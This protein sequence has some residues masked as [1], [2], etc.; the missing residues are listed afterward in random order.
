MKAPSTKVAWIALGSNIGDSVQLLTEAA[1]RLQELS[2]HPIVTSSLW[3]TTPVDCPPGSPLFINAVVGLVPRR[4]ET[5]DSL[6]A[7]LKELEAAFG[8]RAKVVLN[9]PRPL[10]LD[11]IAFGGE[12]RSTEMLALPHP[13][14]HLRRF[15]LAPLAEVAAELMLP[16]QTRSVGEL[17]RR[18]T[19]DEGVRKLGELGFK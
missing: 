18:L 7:R 14:A 15:V 16:G 10:D 6:L 1:R 2:D 9:E 3:Q 19:S 17:L 13:R 11:L 4:D 8:R 5:P 12:T